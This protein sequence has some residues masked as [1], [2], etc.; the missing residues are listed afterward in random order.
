VGTF[1]VSIEIGD[2]Q[3]ERWETVEALVDTGATYSVLPRAILEDLGVV[4]HDRRPFTLADD[5][6]IEL[7]VGHIWVKAEGRS[8]IVLVAF[9]NGGQSL[10]GAVT[11]ETLGLAVNPVSRRLVPVP[12]LLM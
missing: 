5:R 1:R 10:L 11:L 2:T 8:A 6:Q 9:G 4:S 12:G 3:G 7:E